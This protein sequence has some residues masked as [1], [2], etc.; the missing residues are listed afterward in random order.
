ME[1]YN[2]VESEPKEGAVELYLAREIDANYMY[3][4]IMNF[5]YI[6]WYLCDIG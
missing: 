3:R 4:K 2:V 1:K 5:K 6:L